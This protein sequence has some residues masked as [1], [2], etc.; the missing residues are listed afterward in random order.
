METPSSIMYADL[1]NFGHVSNKEAALALLSPR[2]MAGGMSMRSRANSDR[3]FL[4][5]DVVHG[6][7]GRPGP[8][9]FDSFP[10]ATISLEASMLARLGNVDIARQ[11]FLHHYLVEASRQMQGALAQ[12][13]IDANLYTNALQKISLAP[14][15]PDQSRG[16]LYFMLFLVTG[17]CGDPS[18]AVDVVNEYAVSTYR[19]GL[20]TTETSVGPGYAD[21][22]TA[23]D[24]DVYLGLLRIVNGEARLPVQPLSVAPDGTT[25]GALASGPHDITN[26]GYDVSRRHLRIY[27]SGGTWWAQGLGSTNGTRL[28]SG[29]DREVTV[30]EPPKSQRQP[31]RTYGPVRL[32]NSDTLYL[33]TTTQFLVMR[34]AGPE[35]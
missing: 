7:P 23:P 22:L 35:S 10:K 24:A 25:I 34:I 4:S 32:Q 33:G 2:P 6:E 8:E 18:V 13:R 9:S 12:W 31:G 14:H 26:V 29:D 20:Y 3:T 5:R 30:V 1:K 11:Q 16:R 19:Y 28:I 21:A 17:C 15:L 27:R